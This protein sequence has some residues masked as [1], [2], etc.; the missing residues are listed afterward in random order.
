MS[1]CRSGRHASEM[2]YKAA[3]TLMF[4]RDL[5][6]LYTQLL[7]QLAADHEQPHLHTA[8]FVGA[9]GATIVALLRPVLATLRVLLETVV[10]CRDTEFRDVSVVAALLLRTGDTNRFL[11]VDA[12][13]ALDTMAEHVTVHGAV[14]AL[15]AGGGASRSPGVRVGVA[16]L[17]LHLVR[18]LGAGQV[19]GGCR[20]TAAT[21]LC[22]AAELLEDGSQDVR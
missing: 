22:S 21:L 13:E 16:W 7:D 17:L 8:T 14:A 12:S 9:R 4:S 18:T 1:G 10:T 5:V 11:R 3:A 15:V 19:L 6:Q 20:D 2:K